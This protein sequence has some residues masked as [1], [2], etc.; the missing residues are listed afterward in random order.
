MDVIYTSL[1]KTV[2]E[3]H[4]RNQRSTILVNVPLLKFN[5]RLANSQRYQAVASGDGIYQVQI[6]NSR[7]KHIVNLKE[8]AYDCTLFQEYRSPCTHAI[9][10]C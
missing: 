8:E 6:P 7:R 1:M 5:N 10:A 4:H 2:H 9:I 3:R